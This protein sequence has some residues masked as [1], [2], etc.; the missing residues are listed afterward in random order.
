MNATY[1]TTLEMPRINGVTEGQRRAARAA[2][3][4]FTR[5]D[6]S[7]RRRAERFAAVVAVLRY[8]LSLALG[9]LDVQRRT[10]RRSLGIWFARGAA[11]RRQPI[12]VRRI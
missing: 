9:Q 5:I 2:R 7:V 8:L 1:Q 12:V 11:V 3:T 10:G 6:P 4:T